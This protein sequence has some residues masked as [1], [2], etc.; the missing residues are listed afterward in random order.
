MKVEEEEAGNPGKSKKRG[1]WKLWS[2][3]LGFDN[4][5]G[6]QNRKKDKP[7]DE[8]RGKQVVASHHTGWW[9]PRLWRLGIY[10]SHGG[11]GDSVSGATGIA[12]IAYSI[13][14]GC[15][16]VTYEYCVTIGDLTP[17]PPP[18]PLP[19]PPPVSSYPPKTKKKKK[20]FFSFKKKKN[21]DYS[22]VI[23]FRL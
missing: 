13:R 11:W 20:F 2:R 4:W 7:W 12:S 5:R 8:W 21:N 9:R 19:R 10:R 6:R 16:L 17:P 18:P 1:K 14:L 23:I 22:V 15:E 3:E